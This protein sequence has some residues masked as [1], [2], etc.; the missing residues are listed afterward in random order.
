MTIQSLVRA[1]AC[2]AVVLSLACGG[3]N[4]TSPSG[5]GSGSGSGTGSGSGGSGGSAINRGTISA[6]ID[7]VQFTGTATAATNQSGIFA[8]AASNSGAT[9]TFGFGALANAGTTQVNATSPTNAQLV[10]VNGGT[11]QSWS[12]STSGGSGSLTITSINATSATGT[13]AFTLVPS[14][15]SSATGTRAVTNGTFSVTF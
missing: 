3:G 10:V 13:F 15:G 1:A 6:L 14:A 5:S 11:S 12:A 7:G 8:T 4:P 9:I 2:A